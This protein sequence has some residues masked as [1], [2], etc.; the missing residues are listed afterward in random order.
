MFKFSV[1]ITC[2]THYCYCETISLSD[3][4]LADRFSSLLLQNV[5]VIGILDEA[6]N[7]HKAICLIL[8]TIIALGCVIVPILYFD[9]AK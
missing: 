2:G 5:R 8:M 1:I 7:Q 9:Y 4:S 6:I 3:P